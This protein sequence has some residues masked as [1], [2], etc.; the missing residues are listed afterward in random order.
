[1]KAV[2]GLR[3]L[4]LPSVPPSAR[5]KSSLAAVWKGSTLEG[6][7][8]SERFAVF[9]TYATM[10]SGALAVCM[11]LVVEH[12]ALGTLGCAVGFSGVLYAMS[13]VVLMTD[14]PDASTHVHGLQV[15]RRLAVWVDVVLS[16][17]LHTHVSFLGHLGGAAAGWVWCLMI[18]RAGQDRDEQARRRGRRDYGSGR[19]GGRRAGTAHFVRLD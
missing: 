5:M 10:A 2:K 12:L 4:N 8:G 1:M 7:W 17:V 13:A 9:I 15:P 3:A 6:W 11:G 19:V 16:S 14:S 18:S